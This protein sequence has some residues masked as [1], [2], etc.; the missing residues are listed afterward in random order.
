MKDLRDRRYRFDDVV[1]DVRNLRVTV[2]SEI[3]P[4]EPKSFR[5]LLLLVENPGRVLSKEE[6]M[7]E[8]WSGTFVGDNSLARSITQ[9]RKALDDDPK[10]PRYV[11]TVPTIGYR[12]L[13][14]ERL[15][16]DSAAANLPSPAL[17]AVAVLP[18]VNIG[19]D[20]EQDYFCDGLAEEV[21]N[22]LARCIG[23]RVVARTSSFAFKGQSIDV[24]RIGSELAVTH[25][26]EGGVRRV[27]H[28]IRVTA[29][30][31]S[32][33]DGGQIWSGRYDRKLA[34]VFAV[35]D[36]IAQ[37][38][39]AALRGE[40]RTR[41]T[42]KAYTPNLPA[43]ERFLRAMHYYAKHSRESAFH[44][45]KYLEETVEFDPNFAL[46]HAML[47]ECFV[48]F[49]YHSSMPSRTAAPQARSAANTALRLDPSL[50]E[51][52]EVLGRIA[53]LHDY[54]WDEAERE[55][56]LAMGREPVAPRTRWRYAHACLLSTGRLEECEEE[57]R[58]ALRDDPLNGL[59]RF[60][61]AL[62][63]HAAGLLP[64]AAAQFRQVLDVEPNFVPASY[65]LVR[66]LVAEG[67]MVG[68][69]A[70]SESLL[71]QWPKNPEVI[72]GLAGLLMR[73]GD[74]L[75]AERLM[76]QLGDGTEYGA[77]IGFI[78]YYLML[79][80]PQ[81]AGSWMERAIGQRHFVLPLYVR[82]R[83]AIPLMASAQGSAIAS[84]M[85]LPK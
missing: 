65:W 27:G 72:G 8:V 44:C 30:L 12:F 22:A 7:A 23:L 20:K 36:E 26:L 6:I 47:G 63:L 9:I 71:P 73:A 58:R 11:E 70:I 80:E 67:D 43:Y 53:A 82:T 25:V 39:T 16:R 31:V 35:Q 40:L 46:A 41:Q 33:S 50:P 34:D 10:A 1:I 84:K 19:G 61:L 21:L 2:H 85:G 14:G 29:Q 28:R 5:L 55:F 52:H 3:R 51:A 15:E 78:S 66:N 83:L 49:A 13:G 74:A 77:P 79:G 56:R 24:R 81:K 64:E 54:D 57:V 59:S 68:A 60:T 32:A 38:I 37:A 17:P 42:P 62:C 48:E 18:F 4:L 45:K 69:L 75:R 76:N